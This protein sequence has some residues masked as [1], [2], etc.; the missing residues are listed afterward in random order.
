MAAVKT[1]TVQSGLKDR[2]YYKNRILSITDIRVYLYLRKWSENY[3][4]SV[5]PFRRNFFSSTLKI[6][7]K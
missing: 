6:V 5:K 3:K 1:L 4:K 7:L 2:N